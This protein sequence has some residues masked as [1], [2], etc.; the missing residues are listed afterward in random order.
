MTKTTTD[1][2]A[3]T[4][5]AI[6]DTTGSDVERMPSDGDVLP[7]IAT[8][9][10]WEGVD[11]GDMSPTAGRI[12]YLAVNRNLEGGIAD[13]DT[14]EVAKTLDFVWLAKGR[15]RAWFRDPF[16]KGDS[17]PAC[18]SFDGLTADPQ[19]PD[20]QNG[21]DCTSCPLGRWDGAEKPACRESIEALVFLPDPHGVGR[22]ARLRWSGI[23]VGPA[24]NYWD[25]FTTRLPKRPPIAYVSRVTLEPAQTDFGPKLAPRFER[26][27]E[28]GR[29]EA[30]PLI[31][32]RDRRLADWRADVAESV[33]TAEAGEVHDTPTPGPFDSADENTA[34]F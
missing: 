1:E 7:L 9:D 8:D 21:G 26:I 23:A 5:P 3:D 33:A 30:Q 16:G 31:E 32:E 29:R 20:M 18:R 2:T 14:G 24:R 13:P 28:I 17:A 19:S 12:P 11:D 10:E 6:I 34:P 22:L 15:S 25:S 27:G 4:L